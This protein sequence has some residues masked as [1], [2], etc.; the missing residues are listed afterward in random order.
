MSKLFSLCDADVCFK[1]QLPGEDLDALISV[2]N[3][4]DL[5]HMMVEYDCLYRASAKP[6][7]LRF[8]RWLVPRRRLW[9]RLRTR[10]SLFGWE[11]A[12]PGAPTTKLPDFT[13]VSSAPDVSAKDLSAGL[14]CMSEDRHVRKSDE[15]P[16]RLRSESAKLAKFARRPRIALRW[17]FHNIVHD[18]DII[19]LLQVYPTKEP[20]T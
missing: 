20:I 13:P 11:K 9:P 16:R 14:E 15:A 6:A 19:T 7:R 8:N 10:I 1:Y 2:T 4:E 18:G 12:Y 5:E 17:A 3:D